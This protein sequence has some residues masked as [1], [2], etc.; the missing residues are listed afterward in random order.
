MTEKEN[1]LGGLLYLSAD[2][3]L[4][5]D[6]LR[7]KLICHELNHLKPDCIDQRKKLLNSCQLTS[8]AKLM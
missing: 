6:R 2:P 4:V 5:K 7:A 8:R 1:M 3:E